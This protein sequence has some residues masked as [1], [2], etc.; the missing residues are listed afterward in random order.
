MISNAKTVMCLLLSAAYLLALSSCVMVNPQSTPEP[1]AETE[2][3]QLELLVTDRFT[4]GESITDEERGDMFPDV[5]EQTLKYPVMFYDIYYG[6]SF[7]LNKG[8]VAHLELWTDGPTGFWDDD[9]DPEGVV[10]VG[11]VPSGEYAQEWKHIAGS[12]ET[13][14][15]AA[16]DF[17]T[18]R[19]SGGWSSE[20]VYVSPLS[21]YYSVLLWNL[22]KNDVECDLEIS[23]E[24]N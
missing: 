20:I 14:W 15:G 22:T 13:D 19:S 2:P 18:Q 8:E 9:S 24:V 21:G 6:E 7:F 17:A 23:V 11:F 4:L 1:E 5:D 16:Q 10:L 12:E 3:P